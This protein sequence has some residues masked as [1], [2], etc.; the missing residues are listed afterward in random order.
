MSPRLFERSGSGLSNLIPDWL[1]PQ[2]DELHILLQP[3]KL[4]LLKLKRG[5][6][7]TP[8]AMAQIPLKPQPSSSG[9]QSGLQGGL[10]SSLALQTGT[11]TTAPA[12]FWQPAVASLSQ[13]L[14][15]PQWQGC[16]PE[17]VISN[18]FAHYAVIPW[19]E[20]VSSRKEQDGFVRHC[21]TQAYGEFSR[22]WDLRISAPRHGKP[23]LASAIDER[24]LQSLRQAF[25]QAQMPVQHIHPHLVV[26]VNMVRRQLKRVPGLD[27]LALVMLED[28]KLI[29]ALIEH[30]EW[31][32]LQSYAAE[33]DIDNQLLALLERESVIAG[34]DTSAWPL[35]FYAAEGRP[36]LEL[37]GRQVYN[38]PS[39]H[40][41]AQTPDQGSTPAPDPSSKQPHSME[42]WH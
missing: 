16:R 35:V 6:R 31:L 25:Q 9:L 28:G 30:G 2:R 37:A 11:Q 29:I 8:L 13:L 24:L 12:E 3:H 41:S 32:S 18:H 22:H 5:Q 7:R 36:A 21:F 17:V 20:G 1:P 23:M 19:N 27:S 33:A 26:V 34:L 39:A 4:S 40:A 15:Q 38:I 14:Q 10:Q 42:A